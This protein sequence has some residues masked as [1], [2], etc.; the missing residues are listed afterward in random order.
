MGGTSCVSVVTEGCADSEITGITLY[1]IVLVGHKGQFNR[2][3]TSL[4]NASG[5][6]NETVRKNMMW[7][8]V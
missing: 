2:L 4:L 8:A 7:A 1:V 6:L 3:I 5:H